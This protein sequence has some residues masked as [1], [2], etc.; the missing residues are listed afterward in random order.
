[1]SPKA[2]IYDIA[3]ELNISAATVSRALNNNPKISKSTCDL[4]MATATKMNYKQNKLAQ[5]LK[6]GKSHNIGVIVPRINTNFFASVI[7]GIEEELYSHKY[8]VI[9]CQ[10]H[11]DEKEKSK[12]LICC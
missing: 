7:R 11:E 10:T 5:A 9:I 3:K 6:S 8:N 1:M 4:V 2:T 12:T